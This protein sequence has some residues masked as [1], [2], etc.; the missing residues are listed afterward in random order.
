MSRKQQMQKRV[1]RNEGVGDGPKPNSYL[2][3]I[4]EVPDEPNEGGDVLSLLIR[5]GMEPGTKTYQMGRCRIFMSP[6]LAGQGWHMSIANPKRMPTWD[7]VAHAWYTLTEGENIQFAVMALPTKTDYNSY[8]AF[9]L[10]VYESRT[11]AIT[12]VRQPEPPK[13]SPILLPGDVRNGR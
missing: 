3:N 8:H 1:S 2:P 10:H 11:D 4:V 13:K 9:C 12:N 5:A 6:P 7:E